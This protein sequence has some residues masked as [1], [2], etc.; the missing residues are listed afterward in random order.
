M[1]DETAPSDAGEAPPARRDPLVP[2]VAIGAIAAALAVNPY[3]GAFAACVVAA[4]QAGPRLGA[5]KL[6]GLL[7][8]ALIAVGLFLLESASDDW[9]LVPLALLIGG[10][11]AVWWVSERIDRPGVGGFAGTA[12]LG[13]SAAGALLLF[14]T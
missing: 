11:F 9:P 5:T 13:A 10:P 6:G 3:L 1:S 14:A 7:T 4:W 8:G 2:M 12:L